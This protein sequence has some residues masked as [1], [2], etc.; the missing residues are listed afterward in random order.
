MKRITIKKLIEFRSKNDKTKKTFVANL[1]RNK[2]AEDSS[3]GGDYWISCLS[4]IGNVFKYNDD[5]YSAEKI[6]LLKQKI[7]LSDNKGTKTQFQRNIDIL[8]GFEDFELKDIR[9]NAELVFLKKPKDKSIINIKGLPIQARPHHVFSFSENGSDEIGAVWFV[10]K[11]DGYKK[12][13]LGMFTEILYMYLE[14]HYSKEYF[15]NPEFCMTIDVVKGL[16]VNYKD[17]TSGKIPTLLDSTID[18]LKSF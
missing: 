1:K 9:P 15:V 17:L 8:I 14:K 10:S 18:E 3:G 12:S 2:K 4:A 13:E 6:D 7:E 11:L 5:N 16:Q